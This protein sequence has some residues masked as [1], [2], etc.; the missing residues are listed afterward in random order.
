MVLGIR[1]FSTFQMNL[2]NRQSV[3]RATSELQRA[4]QE[5]STGLK[6]N[7]YE[8]LGPSAASVT[9]L[10]GREDATQTFITS[11]SL[12]G[13]KL[14]TM[15]ASVDNA[16][17]EVQSVLEIAVLNASRPTN[18]AE[19]LQLQ[20]RAALEGMVAAMN[21]TFNGDS[22]FAGLDSNKPAL[23]R[24]SDTSA[25]TGRT[26]ES[27]LQEII[28]TG[29][30]DAASATQI[31]DKIDQ[32]FQSQDTVDPSRNFEGTFYQGSRNLD[33]GG[34]PTK[35]IRAWV[36][37]GQEVVFGK[38][39]NEEAFRAAYQGLAMLAATDV[40]TLDEAA[41]STW[42]GRAVDTL[43]VAQKGML[44]ISARIGFN[45]Q[46]VEK[47]QT[48]LTDMSLVQRTQISNYESVDP[49]EAIT[50]MNNLETQLQASYQVTSR[51]SSLSILNFL[52]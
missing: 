19:V 50:R 18:G 41:Y 17:E 11:N 34:Q 25:V 2:F 8:S 52:R 14:T 45:Q 7:I 9:K 20:A 16:R 31:A 44:D 47:A 29:P 22:L 43:A 21:V 27:V 42:I 49:Y 40:S 37:T 48:Q 33:A 30:T 23:T 35:Q 15:L 3:Q 6:A 26:P 4:G 24:W 51:L 28:G 32:V 36:N 5:V 13:N 38:R 12:L 1:S 39:A 10:R 46:I